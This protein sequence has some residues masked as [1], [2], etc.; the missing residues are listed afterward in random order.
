MKHAGEMN[1]LKCLSLQIWSGQQVAVK[2]IFLIMGKHDWISSLWPYGDDTSN[3]GLGSRITESSFHIF[4]S[5]L[6]KP[7][8]PFGICNAGKEA[9]IFLRSPEYFG[10]E[11]TLPPAIATPLLRCVTLEEQQSSPMH[12]PGRKELRLSDGETF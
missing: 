9:G 8:L 3:S 2:H 10:R 12:S 1:F 11:G 5:N 7:A 6:T 4:F